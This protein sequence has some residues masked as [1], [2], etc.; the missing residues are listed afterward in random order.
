MTKRSRGLI[1]ALIV[2]LCIIAI[3]LA[4]LLAVMLTGNSGLLKGIPHYSSAEKYFDSTYEADGIDDIEIIS[5]AGDITV[6]QSTGSQI[7][8]VANG[9]NKELF[10]VE[11]T[12]SKLIITSKA[13]SVN[14]TLM[15][16]KGADI[17]VYV[18]Q[19]VSSLTI[20]SNFGDVDIVG[21][22]SGVLKAESDCG[23]VD[24]D[25]LLGSFNI[26]SDLGDIKIDRI[27]INGSSFASTDMGD[28]EIEST[29][30]VNIIAKTS[31][32]DCDVSK[33][34]P[35]SSVTLN[36]QSSLGDVEVN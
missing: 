4:A 36:V 2:L 19:T 11:Q 32:G 1:I 30:R 13:A 29:N 10:G 21:S 31:L 9:N 24:A 8:V 26:H 14:K 35:D 23:N 22:F 6:K 5:E 27:D 7:R 25:F 20:D 15:N 28:V 17:D 34:A 33:N 18:P 12:D 3:A 16:F